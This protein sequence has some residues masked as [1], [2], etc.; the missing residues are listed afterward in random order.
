MRRL[1]DNQGAT[2]TG[3]FHVE[4]F[5]SEPQRLMF[6]VEHQRRSLSP[7]ASRRPGVC[8]DGSPTPSNP[9]KL[10]QISINRC[11]LAYPKLCWV[12][13]IDCLRNRLCSTWNINPHKPRHPI[14]DGFNNLD[15]WLHS[16]HF[17]NREDAAVTAFNSQAGSFTTYY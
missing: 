17:Y 14:P 15:E 10:R 5:G 6:H 8:G 12:C 9:S 11:A 1:R 16:S 2:S 3:M 7:V 4:H 13:C